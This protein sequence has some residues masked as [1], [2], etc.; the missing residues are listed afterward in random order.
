[1][2]KKGGGGER[3]PWEGWFN[4]LI[5]P[6]KNVPNFNHILIVISRNHNLKLVQSLYRK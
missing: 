3:K 4:K 1:M 5:T 6:Q 2:K